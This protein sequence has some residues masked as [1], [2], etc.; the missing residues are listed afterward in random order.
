MAS[1]KHQNKSILSR[2]ISSPFVQVSIGTLL[3]FTSIIETF[4]IT[5]S[6]SLALLGI[7]HILQALPNEL[8]ALERIARWKQRNKKGQK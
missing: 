1:E 5:P 7:W 2:I 6:H 8:Q 4:W 3:L